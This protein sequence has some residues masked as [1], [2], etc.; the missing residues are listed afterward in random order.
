MLFYFICQEGVFMEDSK[1]F[2]IVVEWMHLEL[3]T[4]LHQKGAQ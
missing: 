1:F 3:R 2:L 4:L